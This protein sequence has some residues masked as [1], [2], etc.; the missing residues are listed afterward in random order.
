MA[1][2][3]SPP[4]PCS[5]AASGSQEERAWCEVGGVVAVAETWGEHCST[6]G[7]CDMLPDIF[8]WVTAP[9]PSLPVGPALHH[10]P[11]KP[12]REHVWPG[13]ALPGLGLHHQWRGEVEVSKKERENI[14][15]HVHTQ[16]R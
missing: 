1:D 9:E 12:I 4:H 10:P 15:L 11:T 16:S 13:L 5:H 3:R 14:D 6:V 7:M 8:V 2:L